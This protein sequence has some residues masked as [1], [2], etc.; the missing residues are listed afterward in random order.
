MLNKHLKYLF[1]SFF[2]LLFWGRLSATHIV[3]GEIFYDYLGSN[4]YKVTLKIYRDCF[5]GL[6]PFDNP[7]FLT[8][9]GASNNVIMTRTL[10][11]L[12][13]TNVPPSINNPCIQT[14]NSVCV[15]EGVYE[16]VINLP[17]LAG[18]YY[19]VYQ[20]C[21]RNNT[22]L[23]LINP[24]AV[25]ATYWE[26]IPGPEKAV[27]N[28]S[29]RFKKFPPIFICNGIPINFDHSA[30]DADGD[31]LVYSLC[32][33][34]NGLDDCCP[35]IGTLTPQGCANPPPSCPTVNTPPP[36][37]GV[38]FLPPYTGAFPM[39]S[40]PVINVNATTG[41]L[42]GTPDINGQWVVGVC[43]QE[44]RAGVLIGTH[45]R[46][47][48]FNVVTC[49][50]TV[51][52]AIM[53]Q[54]QPCSGYTVNFVNQSIGG[55]SFH[56]DFG[57]GGLSS[58]TSIITNPTYVYQDT[59]KYTVTL[60][61]NPGKPCVDTVKKTFYVYPVLAPTFTAP[62][63]QCITGNSFSFAVGGNYASYTTFNWN[64][65]A[66]ASPPTSILV[67]PSGITYSAPGTYAVSV[68]VK[69]AICSKILID[70]VTVL[71]KP[72]AD[73]VGDSIALCDPAV[74]TFTNTSIGGPSVSYLWQFSDGTTST[75]KNPTH[76][77][78]PAGV[79][80]VTL[81]IISSNGCIDTSKFVV[82]G[83]VIVNIRPTA[84]FS[85]LPTNTTIFD[86]DIY[87]FD[88]SIN[89]TSWY[90]TFGDGGS[91]TMVNPSHRYD[92]WGKYEVI[93]TVVNGFGCPDTAVRYVT[94]LP[95]FR[96][97]IPNS[98]TPGKTDG[99]ND[100]FMPLVF[101]VDEYKFDIYDR[102]GERIFHTGD[103]SK[104]W[105]GTYKGRPCEQDVYVW[106]ITFLNQVTKREENHYGHVTLLK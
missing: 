104:G 34:F 33:P 22:I 23:N 15:E 4:N 32:D 37:M 72:K 99:L 1:I 98:F 61:A 45:H 88:E 71:P 42:S 70:S 106:M 5:N 18:G 44:W 16:D 13:V 56:W 92:N 7:A 60:I 55:T 96:F 14:P 69:Q 95:E 85:F 65:G 47:F 54:T 100:V 102:W 97:W 39:S 46:D 101:G 10:S 58:D 67:N 49:S 79:Y 53:D 19:L 86:P 89:S 82:P 62:S 76:S 68:Y 2:C 77:F 43:V 75:D 83:M 73:F 17:P 105:D 11:L 20:R 6:A 80:D 3:G 28:S 48:Q 84:G 9:Y 63:A 24:N 87:F 50:V 35:S 93:Q 91:S 66:S 51:L 12:S 40:S 78:S 30:T 26:H 52:S 81:T 36:Y 59:G 29:P 74:L 21:C 64:F 57:V 41:Y 94:I 27:N 103:T 31:Q 90:Y 38:P 8:V 25:G